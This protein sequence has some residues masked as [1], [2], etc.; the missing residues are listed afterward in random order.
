M[1]YAEAA[2]FDRAPVQHVADYE[3]ALRTRRR[4]QQSRDAMRGNRR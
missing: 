2:Y 4:A 3:D 1:N